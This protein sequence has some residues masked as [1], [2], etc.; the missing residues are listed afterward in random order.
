MAYFGPDSPDTV[1]PTVTMFSPTDGQQYKAGDTVHIE[2]EV[3]DDYEGFGWRLMVPELDQE[4]PVYNGQKV[5]DLPG[6]P[7]GVYTIRVEAVDH[8]RNVGFAEARIYVDIVPGEE[9]TTGEPT[10]GDSSGS[11]DTS[12]PT[13]ESSDG[14]SEASSDGASSDVETAQDSEDSSM[15]TGDDKGCSC[16]TAA[17]SSSPWAWLLLFGGGLGLRRRRSRS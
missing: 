10:T 4:Q 3:S 8:D 1:P 11:S 9:N 16:V 14:A 17:S 15:E 7:K 12:E 5:W 13:G 2:V 6:P